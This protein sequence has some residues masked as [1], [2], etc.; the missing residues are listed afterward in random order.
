[1]TTAPTGGAWTLSKTISAK[2]PP[3]D[4]RCT[5]NPGKASKQGQSTHGES[6]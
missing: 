5:R 1:M 4:R 6:K 2:K 3:I